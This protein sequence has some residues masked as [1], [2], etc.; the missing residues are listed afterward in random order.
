MKWFKTAEIVKKQLFLMAVCFLIS[1]NGISK[2]ASLSR[3]EVSESTFLES[4]S[5][6]APYLLRTVKTAGVIEKENQYIPD[7]MSKLLEGKLPLVSNKDLSHYISLN[8]LK[9]EEI[10]G[11]IDNPI[12]VNKKNVKAGYFVIHDVSFPNFKLQGFPKDINDETWKYNDVKKHWNIKKAHIF[13]GRTGRLYSPVYLSRP[14]RATK[15]EL[16]VLDEQVSKG[17]FIYVYFTVGTHNPNLD[18]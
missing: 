8:G 4:K 11:N 2:S 18:V 16:E 10:G 7:F 3:F 6:Q 17:L 9:E 5:E 12:S 1:S 13:I 14:W 15:F